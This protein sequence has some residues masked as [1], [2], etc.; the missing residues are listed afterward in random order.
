MGSVSAPEGLSDHLPGLALAVPGGLIVGLLMGKIHVTLLP[1]LAGTLGGTLFEFA[2][3]FAA[4]VIAE[5]LHV[6]AILS[7]VAFAMIVARYTP[8]HQSP[9]DRVH[10]Y[11]VWGAVVFLLNVLAFLLMGLQAHAIVVRFDPTQMWQAFGFASIVFVIV[12][13]VRIIWVLF[14]NR[15]VHY[16]AIAGGGLPASNFSQG[17]V[18]SWCGMRGLVTMATALALPL[19]FP[20]RDL[21]VLS[22]FAVVLGTLIVQGLTLGPLI[23]LLRLK[24]DDSFNREISAA[25]MTLLDSAV[26]SLGDQTSGPATRIRADYEAE[27]LVTTDVDDPRAATHGDQL[28]IHTILAQRKKLGEMRRTGEIDDDVYHAL[29]Q[30]LDWAELAALPPE[31]SEMI[32]G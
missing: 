17:L 26:A 9:R 28:R 25:R 6:S 20:S 8:E 27:R 4:W 32:E 13:V 12:V 15:L 3:T 14:Y 5:K 21:I 2:T 11:S 23:R 18:V 30:Q 24:P 10:S 31:R 19:S 22:A 7:V 1:R 16:V 29:E